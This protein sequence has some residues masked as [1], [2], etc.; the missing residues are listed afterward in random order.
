MHLHVCLEVIRRVILKTQQ[1]RLKHIK[2][3]QNM[4]DFITLSDDNHWQIHYLQETILN[5]LVALPGDGQSSPSSSRSQARIKEEGRCQ[6]GHPAIT[7]Y[8]PINLPGTFS[9]DRK[10]PDIVFFLYW[11]C[12]SRMYIMRSK[13]VWTCHPWAF[14]IFKMAL[15]PARAKIVFISI[16]SATAQWYFDT[17]FWV[18]EC[19]QRGFDKFRMYRCYDN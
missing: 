16:F 9:P 1:P 4:H 2:H 17:R 19:R 11:L 7:K 12:I 14:F 3:W 8:A 18:Q 15:H 6:R 13:V 5:R 10:M